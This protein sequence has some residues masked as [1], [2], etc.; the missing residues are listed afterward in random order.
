[1][2]AAIHAVVLT[3]NERDN[4]ARCLESLRW[5]G[6]VCVVDSGSSDGTQQEAEALGAEVF[7]HQQKGAFRIS[8][9]RNWCLENCGFKEG[10]WVLFLDAD[11]VIPTDL[12]LEIKNIVSEHKYDAYEM[13]PRYIF[14]GKW[15]RRTQ[16]F[17]NWHPRLVRVGKAR[18]DGGVWEHFAAGMWVGRIGKPYDHYANSKGFADW[19]KRHDRYSDWDAEKICAYL[20]SGK[21]E[22][23]G[24]ER[25]IGLRKL[26]AKLWPV[27]PLV[28]F[29][30][31]YLF[32]GGWTEGW[33]AL[34]FCL[35]YSFYEL[36]IVV[37]IIENRRRKAGKTL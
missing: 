25:K 33:Q 24:T 28:R 6:R 35:L 1:M 31:M 27:R 13:T 11:E 8:E 17:P 29:V 12:S 34:I 5:C 10:E 18:F 20:S 3:L 23:L 36:M 19:L 7:V 14:M 37:K 9:Q 32:R 26:A 4:M 2:S 15:L 30:H 16:G 22:A 21:V